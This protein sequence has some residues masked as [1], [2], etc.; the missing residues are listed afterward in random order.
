MDAPFAAPDALV[1]PWR[2]AT[3]VATAVAAVELV[4]LM[5]VGVTFLA[6]PVTE[7]VRA[8]AE[9][10]AL[11]PVV[12]QRPPAA[13]GEPKLAR[14]ETSILVLNGNGRAGA[15]A[16]AAERVKQRGYLIGGVGNA[17]QPG[18]ARTFVMYRP[19]FAAEGR[20]LAKDLGVKIVG[21][22]DGMPAKQLLG[23]HVALVLGD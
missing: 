17:P 18:V 20:R 21:P 13:P 19:G 14:G 22:L 4:V 15:A 2:T 9:A 16:A 12:K 6:D 8:A 5:V 11:A 7:R 1:R 10:D 23:A 3:I